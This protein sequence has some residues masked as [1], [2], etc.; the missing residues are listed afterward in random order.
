MW[1]SLRPPPS[2]P[3][4]IV[5]I[6]WTPSPL[7]LSTWLLNDP[8]HQLHQI[9]VS[10]F[11]TKSP[12]HQSILGLLLPWKEGKYDDAW[13]LDRIWVG[14]DQVWILSPGTDRS[15]AHYKHLLN[16]HS[17]FHFLK[18]I[19]LWMNTTSSKCETKCIWNRT[20]KTFFLY[21]K[22]QTWIDFLVGVKYLFLKLVWKNYLCKNDFLW[23]KG[24]NSSIS[25]FLQEIRGKSVKILNVVNDNK[26]VSSSD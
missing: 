14:P 7:F 19:S 24:W 26:A 4:T 11:F 25:I 8:Y 16:F 2:L 3:W 6:W 20:L 17:N 13:L 5:D 22:I 9:K 23:F 10:I 15:C 18:K 21:M 12:L 1:T